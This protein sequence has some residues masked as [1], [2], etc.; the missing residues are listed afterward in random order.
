MGIAHQLAAIEQGFR[1]V[2]SFPEWRGTPIIL[3]ESDPEGC[4]ACSAKENP[5]N[6]YRNGPLFACYTAEVL[7]QIFYLADRERVNFMGAVTWSFEFEDQPYF[8]GFRELATNGIG[9]PVF[10][11]FRMFGLL[12]DT[13]VNVTSSGALG[14]D[15]IVSGGVRGR[16]D[17]NAIA[18]RKDHE[19]DILIWNYHDDDLPSEAAP[20]DLTITGLPKNATRGLLEQ[21][22]IDSSHSNAFAAWKEMRSPQSPS[23]VQYEQLENAGQLQLLNSP[24]WTRIE[25]GSVRLQFALPRQAVSLVRIAW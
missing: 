6:S 21:F 2:A 25:K 22:R 8:E 7:N 1:I 5:Q 19:A 20:V 24:A 17:I 23:P 15:E 10:N 13:R 9:K 4:A 14:N 18:T 3:G 11:A 16:A 12:G